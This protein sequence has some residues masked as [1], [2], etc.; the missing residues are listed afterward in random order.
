MA[1]TH[2]NL[3][4]SIGRGAS[5]RASPSS[6]IVLAGVLL[7]VLII[8]VVQGRSA[9]IDAYTAIC[10]ALGILPGSP[11]RPAGCRSHAA[12]AGFASGMDAGRA[13][14]SGRRQAGARPR[15]SPGGLRRLPWRTGRVSRA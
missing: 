10:R 8:P 11:A 4:L 1:A 12:D 9:G 3:M 6:C 15:E 7:G 14:N 2:P 13:A 5:G